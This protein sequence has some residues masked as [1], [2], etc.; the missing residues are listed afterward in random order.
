MNRII[1][2]VIAVSEKCFYFELLKSTDL[3]NGEKFHENEH[4]II[5][6]AYTGFIKRKH[7]ISIILNIIH[8]AIIIIIP[9]LNTNNGPIANTLPRK[10]GLLVIFSVSAI[11]YKYL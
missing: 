7:L 4:S 2:I 5:L 1:I 3:Y 11:I 9:S 10:P 6:T 8:R